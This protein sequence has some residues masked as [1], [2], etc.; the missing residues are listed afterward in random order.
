MLSLIQI[1]VV[2][3]PYFELVPCVSFSGFLIF[4]FFFG[5]EERLI[6]PYPTQFLNANTCILTLFET[7]G[8]QR[9]LRTTMTA[10]SYDIS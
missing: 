4:E 3:R 6:S 2:E 5:C 8:T 1:C 7:R 10:G 9:I